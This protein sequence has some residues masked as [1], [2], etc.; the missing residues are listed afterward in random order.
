M[1]LLHKDNHWIRYAGQVE[2]GSSHRLPSSQRNIVSLLCA[3]KYHQI[4][5]KGYESSLQALGPHKKTRTHTYVIAG[6]FA[7]KAIA[8]CLVHLNQNSGIKPS[9]QIQPCRS[10]GSTGLSNFS[11]TFATLHRPI[12]WCAASFASGKGGTKSTSCVYSD[13]PAK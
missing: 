4:A 2:G 6:C 8:A 1:H 13:K 12:R 10:G 5:P 7:S 9:E 11:I 3:K